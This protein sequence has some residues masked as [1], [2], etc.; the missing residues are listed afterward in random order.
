M[1]RQK[2]K[3]MDKKEL[4]FILQEGEGYKLEFKESLKNIDKEIVAFANAEGGRIFL[5]IDDN[6]KIKGVKTDNKL[7]SQIQDIANNCDPSIQIGIEEFNDILII[8]VK[9]GKDKPYKCSS[10]FYLRQGPNSQKMGRDEI[11]EFAKGEGKIKFDSQ[12]N[13][14][15]D[16][17]KDFDKEKLDAYLIKANLSKL[18]PARDI[19]KDLGTGDGDLNNAG[20]LFFSKNPQ[21]FIPNSVFT[22]VLFRDKEGSNVID[23]KEVTG[24][25]AEIVEKTMEFAEFHIKVGYKF[26]GKPKR[27]NIFEYPL[28]AIRESVINSVMHKN[29]FESGHNNIL[30]IFPDKIQIENVWIKPHHFR[31]KETVFRRNPIIAG[32]FSRIHFGEKLG[33]GFARMEYYCKKENAPAP[34][35]KF[36]ET[37]FYVIF[38]PNPQYLKLAKQT[39]SKGWVDGWVDGLAESQKMILELILEDQYIS[40]RE[41]SDQIKISDTAVD[42]NISKLK[43]MGL[44]RRIGPAKGGYWK[45]IKKK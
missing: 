20:V 39:E 40:K 21:Q 3:K 18:I 37:H 28:E 27:E 41:L 25:L 9:E 24:S 22:C 17:K 32:L 33:S 6:N 35:V 1:D 15:F 34:E 19:L 11:F 8:A 2:A 5:G 14:E 29:Y 4:N 23:R 42:K 38:K 7:K 13:E 16:F 26:T 12:I 31:I 45:V 10:G 36:T 30:K 44:L 43:K